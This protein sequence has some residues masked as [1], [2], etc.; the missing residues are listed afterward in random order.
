M[1]DSSKMDPK[2][3]KVQELKDELARRGLVGEGLK[4]DLIQ[5]LQAALDDEEFGDA[6]APSDHPVQPTEIDSTPKQ[7]PV[8]IPVPVSVPAVSSVP[9]TAAKIIPAVVQNIKKIEVTP[10]VKKVITEI[11]Q[12]VVLEPLSSSSS[13][14]AGDKLASRAE[15]FGTAQGVPLGI[16]PTENAKIKS[17]AERFNI[18]PTESEKNKTRAER[19]GVK[20]ADPDSVHPGKESD[21]ETMEKNKQRA[22]RFGIVTKEMELADKEAKRKAREAKFGKSDADQATDLLLKRKERFVDP[23]VAQQAAELEKRAKRFAKN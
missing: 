5:R 8:P 18:P 15:R 1:S 17:R 10:V 6:I 14:A 22:L 12:P 23:K 13:S 16:A 19:F 21:V 3:L 4:P 20:S 9:I 11:K 2:K 7:Q